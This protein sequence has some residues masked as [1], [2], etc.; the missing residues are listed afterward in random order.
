MRQLELQEVEDILYG[1]CLYGAGGGGSLTTALNRARDVYEKGMKVTLIGVDEVED[2]W[3]AVSPYYVGNMVPMSEEEAERF[4]NLAILPEPVSTLAAR[5]LERFLGKPVSAVVSTELGG[6]TACAMETAAWLGVPLVD[7]DPAG[8]AVPELKHTTFSLHD[9]TITPFSLANRYGDT[10]IVTDT[11]NDS[12]ADTMARSFA[13]R[14]GNLAGIC[15]HPVEGAKLKQA[16]IPGTLSMSQAM[17]R[18]RR[19]ACEEG[20]APVE[21]ILSAG[22]GSLF[23]QGKITDTGY[24]HSL[25]FTDGFVD[26]EET[27][28]ASPRRVTVKYRY[29]HMQMIEDGAIVALIPDIITLVDPR[30]GIPIMNPNCEVGMDVAI[31]TFPSPDVWQTEEG[32]KLFGPS[33][34]GLP[35]EAYRAVRMKAPRVAESV[36]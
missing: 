26:I 32:I 13:E 14:F 18:A 17:G 6:T 4:E 36:K 15:D 34:I 23:L 31:L 24:A 5:A 33:Y 3:L 27:G 21:A 35:E 30:T 16:I 8:R 9:V 22:E 28:V 7:G 2:E 25:G 12:H 29:E 11:V 20:R 10:M 1:A 19:L